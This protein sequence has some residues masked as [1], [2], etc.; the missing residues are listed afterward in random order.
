MPRAQS[1]RTAAIVANEKEGF[2]LA[3]DSPGSCMRP[4][5]R[6]RPD[7]GRS[8][9]RDLIERARASEKAN[10]VV[11]PSGNPPKV[12]TGVYKAELGR[13]FCLLPRDDGAGTYY[14]FPLARLGDT[15]H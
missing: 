10:G 6:F 1:D 12:R 13:S 9:P 2:F 11:F 5:T 15:C 14:V 3:S 8:V 7:S 4:S